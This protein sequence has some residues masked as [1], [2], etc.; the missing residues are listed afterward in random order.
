MELTLEQ[1]ESVRKIMAGMDCPK[2]FVCRKEGFES[3]CRAH[4][5]GGAA[6]VQCLSSDSPDCCMSYAFSDDVHF[7]NCRL[8][9]YAALELGR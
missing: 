8:R 5:Y 7:C 1:K 6:L 9:R 4:V 2:G 3:L